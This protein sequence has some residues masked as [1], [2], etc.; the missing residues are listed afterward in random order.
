MHRPVQGCKQSLRP[1]ETQVSALE[2]AALCWLDTWTACE[3]CQVPL[4]WV[5]NHGKC[6]KTRMG[7]RWQASWDDGI[8]QLGPIAGKKI[9]NITIGRR[10]WT[11]L[12]SKSPALKHS[13]QNNHN[14]RMKKRPNYEVLFAFYH[15]SQSKCLSLSTHKFEML[16]Q[17]LKSNI[18]NTSRH[19]K[20]QP[21]T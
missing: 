15:C 6:Q 1:N 14:C 18:S 11:A 19:L 17:I 3:A 9:E 8:Q 20:L 21:S 16:A 12:E 5:P 13:Q 2:A 4:R 10:P 7:K